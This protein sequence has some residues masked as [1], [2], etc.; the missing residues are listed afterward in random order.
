MQI[1]MQQSTRPPYLACRQLGVGVRGGAEAAVHTARRFAME[2]SPGKAIVKLD[3]RNAFNCLQRDAMLSA[4]FHEVPLIYNFCKL[5]YAGDSNLLFADKLI[6]SEVGAQQGDPLGPL[7]FSLTIHPIIQALDSE[8]VLGYLDD[9][10]L[11]GDLVVLQRDVALVEEKAAEIGLHLNASKCELIC[12][13]SID[14]VLSGFEDFLK[15]RVDEASLL[16]SPLIPGAALDEILEKRVRNL[17]TAISRLHLLESHDALLILKNSLSSPKL[18]YNLR[19]APCS[20]HPGLEAFDALLRVA[21]VRVTNVA[22]DDFQW[23]QASLPVRDGGLGIRSV[24]LL[25]P[26]AF[27]ASAAATRDLQ[28]QLLP[29]GFSDTDVHRD[30]TLAIWQSRHSAPG[31]LT[32]WGAEERLQA[33][34]DKASIA[35]GRDILVNHCTNKEDRA[36]LLASQHAHSGDWL[37]AWPIS[38][39]GLRLSNDDI[40]VGVGL[41]LGSS[42]CSPHTCI[43]SNPVTAR[44]THGLS[45]R[46]SK[47]RL[48]RHALL[49]DA[50]HRGLLRAG[51]QN[52]LEPSGL[53]RTD[54]KRPDGQTQLA[55]K[56]GRCMTWDVTVSDTFA[57]SHIDDTSIESGAAAEKAALNKINKYIDLTPHYIFIPIA[58][59]TMGP[60]CVEGLEFLTALGKRISAKTGDRR[61]TAFLLQR[62]SIIIQRCNTISHLGT[63]ATA[64]DT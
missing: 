28:Y 51:I 4:V 12:E 14:G 45:C 57:A 15:L 44:G 29:A 19:T 53:S 40:R 38:A 34:W 3:F 30:N 27:L 61:E 42:L 59:E 13:G 18:M 37:H 62:I 22:I 31:T 63:F 5:A 1:H 54:S 7:L 9:L 43:C 60:I 32:P 39:C 49:N 64:S 47:G 33:S 2:L 58:M 56:D 26:S 21:L 10:T 8:M 48:P 17:E 36:R 46:Q 16:G 52:K 50:V 24:A 6:T 35:L 25:A 55:W 41:R 23:V 11:G 20:E